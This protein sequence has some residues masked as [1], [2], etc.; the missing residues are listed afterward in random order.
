MRASDNHS[1]HCQLSARGEA[2]CVNCAVAARA[3]GPEKKGEKM[4]LSHTPTCAAGA[5]T[6]ECALC[7]VQCWMY[8]DLITIF[9]V[10]TRHLCHQNMHEARTRRKMEQETIRALFCK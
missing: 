7:A 3:L 6:A 4:M 10:C 5:A 2:A 8:R 9:I 1:K